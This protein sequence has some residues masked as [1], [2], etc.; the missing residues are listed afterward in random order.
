MGTE[1]LPITSTFT[2]T[3]LQAPLQ[4]AFT[5][6]GLTLNVAVTQ[7]GQMSEFMLRPARSGSGI[8]GAVV[9]LR[10][11]DWLRELGESTGQVNGTSARQELRK[12]LDEFLVQ[13]PLLAPPGRS[14]WLLICPSAG[15]IA[16]QF[17]LTALCRTFTNLLEAR[18]RNVPRINVLPWPESLSSEE[19]FDRELDRTNHVPFTQGAFAQLSESLADHLSRSLTSSNENLAPAAGG[20]PELANFLAGLRVRVDVA[21]ASSNSSAD[22]GRIL[23]TAASFSLAG[24]KPALSDAEVEMIIAAQTCWVISVSDRLSDYGVSGVLNARTQESALVIDTMSLS[25]PVLGKQVEYAVLMALQ[26]I[27]ASRALSELV[28]EYRDSGRNQP[29]LDYLKSIATAEREQRYVIAVNQAETR[30]G[31]A[32]VAPEAWRLTVRTVSGPM[33]HSI[34]AI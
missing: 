19:Y 5:K 12:R 27:A 3:P 15:W 33:L 7:Y 25:C 6:L 20:S 24:E 18:L 17:K 9:L 21:A 32:A 13:L 30:V 2:A 11:E 23:R 31:T 10:L 26:Q 16:E 4:A 22:V 8:V 1:H 14:I 34:S 28:F 29:A